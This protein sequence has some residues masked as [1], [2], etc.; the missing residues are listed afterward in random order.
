[1]AADRTRF[2]RCFNPRPRV[3]G[4]AKRIIAGGYSY[5][6]NPRPRVGGDRA[7][8]AAYGLAQVSIHAPA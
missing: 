2:R 7:S 4:D 3:G 1:M 6:F 8:A 5:S